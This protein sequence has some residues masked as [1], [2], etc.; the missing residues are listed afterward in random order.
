M[1]IFVIII[2]GVTLIF[3][4]DGLIQLLSTNTRRST[5][6]QMA[7]DINESKKLFRESEVVLVASMDMAM[8]D[9]NRLR[10]SLTGGHS[11]M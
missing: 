6:L 1:G 9:I 5:S 11:D 2:V 7:Q 4:C 8:R 10:T 3:N